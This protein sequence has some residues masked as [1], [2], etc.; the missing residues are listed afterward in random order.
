VQRVLGID[1]GTTNSVCA[2]LK[3]GDPVILPIRGKDS[4]SSV[5]GV[6]RRGDLLVGEQAKSRAALDPENV[7]YSVKRFMGRRY[8]SPDVQEV[9]SRLKLAY[10]V[11][12][13]DGDVA[14]WFHGRTYSPTEL[15]SLILGRLK[16]EAEDAAGAEFPRAVITV[17]A[18]FTE[19]QVAA[20]REAGRMAGFDVL[21]VLD[22]PTAAALA[23]NHDREDEDDLTAVVFDLGGGTFDISVLEMIGGMVN[24]LNIE[25]D[26]LL[27][28]DDFDDVLAGQ[29]LQRIRVEEGVDLSGDREARVLLKKE[30]EKA[31]TELS[32]TYVTDIVLPS[33]GQPPVVFEGEVSR[34]EFV[35]LVH[36]RV[37]AA[38]AL[39]TKAVEGADRT[40]HD[41][42]EVLLVGGST[43]IPY[44]QERLAELFGP[45][46]IRKRVHPMKSVA[47]GAAVQ[48]GFLP[49][50]ECAECGTANPVAADDCVGCERPLRPPRKTACP[51]CFLYSDE[52][53]Q[54]CGKCGYDL[55][56]DRPTP[57]APPTC[58]RCG[59]SLARAGLACSR[60][61]T[62]ADGLRCASCGTVNPAGV[63][64][65]TNPACGRLLE[66]PLQVTGQS[67]GIAL[68]DG[69]FHPILPKGTYFPTVEPKGEDFVTPR[70]N[71]ARMEIVV[72]QGEHELAEMNELTGYLTMPL[73]P[74]LPKGAPVRVSFGLDDNRMLTVQVSVQ[75]G[76]ERAAKMNHGGRLDPE[77]LRLVEEQRRA[78][79]LF[80]ARWSTEL[81]QAEALVFDIETTKLEDILNGGGG[82]AVAEAAIASTAEAL[83]LAANV[84]AGHAFLSAARRALRK[85]IDRTDDDELGRYYGE[86]D[87]ARGRADW[88]EATRL[89][90]D[91]RAAIG[92]LGPEMLALAYC[93]TFA[94]QGTLPPGMSMRV[95]EA[96]RRYD[97][98]YDRGDKGGMKRALRALRKLWE[99]EVKA[100]VV[101]TRETT[102]GPVRPGLAR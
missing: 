28:G 77:I 65:C 35:D 32:E 82:R 58:A 7:V 6:G 22:E 2:Y 80:V 19:R 86:I 11:D 33:I 59:A 51:R 24:V 48:G 97:E 75:A 21:R 45:E 72:Y 66:S 8:G 91:A 41:I 23:Y 1:L 44:V 71:E 37:D 14:I 84:R 64:Q 34:E 102:S 50:V 83:D 27:G 38:V 89:V 36:E 101:G 49:T 3:R 20:T 96:V 53:T 92:R 31:K 26:N 13:S 43:A 94:G 68:Q 62:E 25:G 29:L 95:M 4:I 9:L 46:K 57:E 42:D 17:P 85:Y 18:Y 40:L 74:N 61:S 88:H 54:F 55:A 78:V 99:G 63:S 30:A 56:D 10:R 52:G 12:D 39:V 70:A 16:K 15:S 60:C 73:P 67:L 93:R 81:S 90:E 100:E 98:A 47:L 79:E 87:T 76:R 5:L 69:R